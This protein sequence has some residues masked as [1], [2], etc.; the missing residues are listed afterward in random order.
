MATIF[1]TNF[2]D[3]NTTQNGVLYPSLEGTAASDTIY[4]LAGNDVLGSYSTANTGEDKMY[5]GSGNDRYYVNSSG[6]VVTESANQGTDTVYS[7]IYS[8]TLTANVENLSLFGTAYSGYGNGLNNTIYGT[9]SANYL[10]GGAGVDTM[11]GYGGNDYY[12]VDTSSDVVTEFANQGTDTVYSYASTYTLTANVE[13]LSLFG[14]AYSGYGNGLNNTIY[15]TNSANYLNGGAG[16]D[17]MY[18]YGGND[19]YVVDNSSDVV[20]EFANQGTDTVYSYASTYTLTA[21]VESL[22]LLGTAY[23]GYGNG[24]NNTIYG[25]SSSNYLGGGG[26]NDTIYGDGGSD[27]INGYNTATSSTEYD[28]LSGG[29]GA[30]SFILGGSWGVSYLGAGYASITDWSSIDYIEAKG[31]AS[32]YTLGYGNYEGT[33]ALDTRVFYQ[34][35]LIAL[36]R[37]TTN[38]NIATDF[39]FV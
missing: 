1:G 22:S 34:G 21:N 16:V 4:G 24:L 38:V 6:D 37:D 15:G 7:S 8:Y 31:T 5:G 25:T 33:S 23:S 20:T 29:S 30:D 35:D 27:R 13:N 14:T 32:Q 3:N 19:Y 17:T 39:N 11:Y 10:N 2:N 12:V 18:G 36:I 26:G 28:T 9:N